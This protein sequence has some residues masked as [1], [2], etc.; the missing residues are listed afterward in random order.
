MVDKNL[1]IVAHPDDETIW[2]G[3]VILNKCNEEWTILSLCR[4]ED[5]DRKPKFLKICDLFGAKAI[6]SDLD[7]EELLPLD[8][9]L[10]QNKIINLLRNL[11][12]DYIYT[13][14]K[15]GEYGH[16][17]HKEIHE[18]VKELVKNK[19]LKCKKLFFFDYVPGEESSKH[20]KNLKIPIA[21]GKADMIF[22]LNNK[23]LMKKIKL[24]SETYGFENDSFEVRSCGEW[25]GFKVL[26]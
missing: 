24:V 4:K 8:P 1:V 26:I 20:D 22:K 17:R 19:V 6:I 10:I 9:K 7:D 12:F 23:V 15:N 11:S 14:G 16:I 5:S 13:H 21:N 2:M 3:G 18:A 25:E